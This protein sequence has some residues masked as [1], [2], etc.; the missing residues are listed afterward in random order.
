MELASLI[1]QGQLRTFFVLLV[2]IIA[3]LS[4]GMVLVI[5]NT[6]AEFRNVTKLQALEN[7]IGWLC[8]SSLQHHRQVPH[9]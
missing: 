8:A 3:L 4:V 1:D 2:G 5:G 7:A 9:W 6:L